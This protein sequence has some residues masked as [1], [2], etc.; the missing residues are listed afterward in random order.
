MGDLDLGLYDIY[1]RNHLCHRVLNLDPWIHFNEIIISLVVDQKFKGACAPVF[2][3][4]RN[5]KGVLMDIVSN[6]LG[7]GKG[8]REFH[9]L[10]V[11]S[12]D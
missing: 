6:F 5:L 10:L 3:S 9:D 7:D 4:F 1:P 2:Y 12:L 11:P 8:R